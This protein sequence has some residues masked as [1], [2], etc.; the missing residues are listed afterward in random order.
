MPLPDMTRKQQKAYDEALKRIIACR[1]ERGTWL[2]LGSLGLPRLPPEIGQ[3]AKL[4]LL[5]ADNN[6]LS[7]LPPEIG[8]LAKLTELNLENNQLSTLPSE[9]GQL[10]NLTHLYL[11]TNRLTTLPPR[12]GQLANLTRLVLSNNRL[13]TLP[14]EIG[15]LAK[16]TVLAFDNNQLSTLPAEIGRLTQLAQL[17]LQ[18]NVLNE[19]P[20]SLKRLARL[21]ELTLH[22]NDALGLPT[23]LSG[24]SYYKSGA[25]SP[26]AK[27]QELL[28]YYFRI[29]APEDRQPLNEFKLI[30][31]GRGG[32]GK[33][34]LVHRL[35]HGEFK[36]FKPTNGIAISQWPVMMADTRVRAHVWDFGGQEI[37]HGTHRFFMTERALYL[38]LVTARDNRAQHDAEYWLS[39]I[40]SFAGDVPVIVLLH[41]KGEL[42]CEVDRKIIREKYGEEIEFLETDSKLALTMDDLCRKIEQMSTSLPDLRSG[43]P[44]A[45]HRVKQDL[46]EA[47]EDWLTFDR[48]CDFCTER[49]VSKHEDQEALARNLHALGLMLAFRNDSELKNHGVLKPQWATTGIYN[50]LNAPAIKAAGA[51]FTVRDLENILDAKTYPAAV[52]PFLLGLMEK[53][54]LCFPLD[55]AHTRFM[56]PELLPADEPDLAKEFPAGESLGFAYR[57]DRVLPQGLLPRFIVETFRYRD[58]AHAWRTGVVLEEDNCRAW[59]RG[60]V[61]GRKISVRVVGPGDG[62]R[63]MLAVVRR[64]LRK[65]HG[66]F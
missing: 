1:R 34:T 22:G 63:G 57:Y 44:K 32:V 15:Q 17:I 52:H 48:F 27:P 35:V 46:P 59:V 29:Y 49:G 47:P 30:L 23:E 53:F 20:K 37:M 55:E 13:T 6:Q 62:R 50:L 61:E 42:P 65:I 25:Q 64:E 19:L 12:L 4:T 14:P 9:I 51:K 26:P 28:D 45:W 43:W 8:Q 7:T 10:A 66:I 40:R 58:P 31:V 56:I 60:D 18:G 5:R 3:L 11:D 33:T 2:D 21:K 36:E 38:V 41:K 39:L 24:S 16:L 54:K